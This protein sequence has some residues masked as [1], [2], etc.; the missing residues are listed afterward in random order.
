MTTTGI[1][2]FNGMEELDFVGPWEVFTMGWWQT[3]Q[4]RVIAI[5]LDDQEVRCAKGMHV[6]PEVGL[7]GA[8]DLDV[9]VVPGGD[10][11]R[12]LMQNAR[13]LS[14]LRQRAQQATWTSSVCTGSLVLAAAGLLD[15]RAATTHW[16]A[17]AELRK[18]DKIEVVD[19]MRFVRDGQM[20][21][22]AGV[23]AGIDMALWLYGQVATPKDAR[24]VQRLMQYDPAPPYQ[25]AT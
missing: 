13:L 22:A 16:A 7:D 4:D 23:S 12:P 3:P 2:M 18:F 9:L 6:R 10:G 25:A 1:L 24:Q 20:V 21:T 19:N 8:P 17:L 11:T 14:W 15:G 5:G